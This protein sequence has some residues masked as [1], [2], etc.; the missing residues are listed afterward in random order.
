M[1]G[2]RDFDAIYIRHRDV[3]YDDLRVQLQGSLDA[4]FP[5]VGRSHIVAVQLENGRTHVCDHGL[6]IDDNGLD[7]DTCV[8]DAEF[9]CFAINYFDVRHQWNA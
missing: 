7:H 6:I 2:L 3:G 9:G 1:N 8:V 4:F 5:A